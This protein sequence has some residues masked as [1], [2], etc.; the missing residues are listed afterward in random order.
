MLKSKVMWGEG[1]FLRPQHFQQQDQYHESRLQLAMT[2]LHPYL[3]GIRSLEIDE[4][5]LKN[6]QLRITKL[7]VVFPDGTACSA[8]S[9]DELP[10]VLDLRSMDEPAEF[11]TVYLG[12]PSLKEHGNNVP[13]SSN[14]TPTITRFV[15]ENYSAPDQYTDAEDTTVCLLRHA[16]H[17]FVEDTSAAQYSHIPIARIRKSIE[18][19][20]ALDK[21]YIPPVV[22]IASSKE[23]GEILLGLLDLLEAKAAALREQNREPSK[24]MIE[25]RA[26][27]HSLFWLQQATSGHYAKLKHLYQNQDFHPERLHQEMMS[28]A[29]SLMSFSKAY[30]LNELPEYDHKN[31]KKCLGELDEMIRDLTNVVVSTRYLVIP[32]SSPRPSFWSAALNSDKITNSTAFYLA[33]SSSMPLP[34]LIDTFPM[35]VKAGAPDDVEKSLQ[36]ATPAIP[37]SHTPQVPSAIPVKPNYSY[38]AVNNR[39]DMYERMMKVRSMSIYTP[40]SL[41]D[42]KIELIAV[43]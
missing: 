40:D 36:A 21:S 31:L 8:P 12:V 14:T 39:G 11:S 42:L 43:I 29:A 38:F 17:A 3:W 24:N 19:G 6:F 28:L 22:S 26:D 20:Y 35:Q 27:D 34:R 18:G 37:I 25:F 33:V 13:T 41:S 7:N 10:P 5:A 4:T 15:K 30:S 1:L 23:M 32:L 9:I 2:L 16:L